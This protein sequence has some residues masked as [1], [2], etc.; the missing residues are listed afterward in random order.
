MTVTAQWLR[1]GQSR[2]CGHRPE[3]S[4]QLA[5]PCS[6]S[7]GISA[8][9]GTSRAGGVRPGRTGLRRGRPSHCD[10]AVRSFS[11]G[12]PGHRGGLSGVAGPAPSMPG[13]PH[14]ENHRRPQTSSVPETALPRARAPAQREGS[15]AC[16]SAISRHRHPHPSQTLLR[17]SSWSPSA[18]APRGAVHLLRCPPPEHK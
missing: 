10:L 4:E 14:C 7:W 9:S 8:G 5:P 16:F 13:A 15:K 11:V 1:E 17:C 6:V 3:A 18:S 12:H 2:D